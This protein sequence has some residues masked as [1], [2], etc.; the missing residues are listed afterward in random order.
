[1]TELG[2]NVGFF[3]QCF[4]VRSLTRTNFSE[5]DGGAWLVAYKAEQ[6]NRFNAVLCRE[7]DVNLSGE[8]F[9]K[10]GNLKRTNNPLFDTKGKLDA[11]FLLNVC[12]VADP[13]DV[14]S[15]NISGKD[16][17][18]VNDGDFSMFKN[19]FHIDAGENNLQ[20]DNFREFPSLKSLELPLNNIG[21]K[22]VINEKDFTSLDTLDM[23]CNSLTENDILALGV[24]PALKVLHLTGNQ[25]ES[26]PTG[27]SKPVSN[28]QNTFHSNLEK[29]WLDQNYLTDKDTFSC[30]ADLKRLKYL[31]LAHNKIS[32][33]PYLQL[34]HAKSKSY[35]NTTEENTQRERQHMLNE[36]VN[37]KIDNGN[38]KKSILEEDLFG[39]VDSERQP[40]YHHET[41]KNQC[42]QDRYMSPFSSL[43][44]INLANNHIKDEEDLLELST[45]PCLEKVVIWGNPV[46][47]SGRWGPPMV[48]QQLSL[49]AGIE[50][51]RYGVQLLDKLVIFFQTFYHQCICKLIYST[52]LFN[53]TFQAN[54][55]FVHKPSNKDKTQT[56]K[57][58][59]KVSI[60]CFYKKSSNVGA[61]EAFNSRIYVQTYS[62][63]SSSN[64]N[65]TKM[66]DNQNNQHDM[67]D[68]CTYIDDQTNITPRQTTPSEER[69]FLTQTD[70]DENDEILIYNNEPKQTTIPDSVNDKP[71]ISKKYKG[72]E[73]LLTID[74]Q[75]PEEIELPRTIQGNV[76]ALQYVLDHPLTFTQHSLQQQKTE[77]TSKL[78]RHS[79]VTKQLNNNNGKKIPG[80]TTVEQLGLILDRMC[81]HKKS[82]E[83]NLEN[84]LKEK[85]FKKNK[86][87]IKEAKRLLNE[88]QKKYNEVRCE[89]LK[90]TNINDDSY[91]QES[92]AGS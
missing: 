53:T 21:G 43:R 45:W 75:Y 82:I 32:S 73:D 28:R 12:C 69:I 48:M 11:K 27:M 80:S 55:F 5:G 22:V 56:I 34:L 70:N 59:R 50:V 87:E 54:F 9:D 72:Y 29:L 76:T 89:S 65:D 63:I 92:R 18:L 40:D 47:I 77:R 17:C 88:V 37:Q 78:T 62:P 25:L 51:T 26:L 19:V 66:D 8:W 91:F 67:N 81:L 3:G 79:A 33:V 39:A 6:R 38:S 58:P 24:L 52:F 41:V 16:L 57:I 30:L 20:L 60:R 36:M 35:K 61:T 2:K 90:L 64:G 44:I 46:A 7:P 49:V 4:P 1:M 14:Y 23:S 84:F 31:N 74:E 85:N 68:L 13:L 86:K 42:N 83:S 10:K 15:I 71:K